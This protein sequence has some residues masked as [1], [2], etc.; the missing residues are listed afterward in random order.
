[1]WRPR[2]SLLLRAAPRGADGPRRLLRR[3]RRRGGVR[4][5]RARQPAHHRPRR[6][7]GLPPRVRSRAGEPPPTPRPATIRWSSLRAIP[8][9]P[10]PDASQPN[11]IFHLALVQH[12][13]YMSALGLER[14]DDHQLERVHPARGPRDLVCEPPDRELERGHSEQS[15][16]HRLK[17]LRDTVDARAGRY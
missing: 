5:R 11:A 3:A 6:V 12:E 1:G 17:A 8:F 16:E 2:R 7:R 9:R 10:G 15:V 4:P 13:R 14:R